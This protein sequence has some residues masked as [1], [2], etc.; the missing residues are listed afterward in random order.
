MTGAILTVEDQKRLMREATEKRAERVPRLRAIFD[1]AIRYNEMLLDN[2]GWTDDECIAFARENHAKA[3]EQWRA[4]PQAWNDGI[5][6]CRNDVSKAGF[7]LE[8]LASGR[9]LLAGMESPAPGGADG[10]A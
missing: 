10:R 4:N 6:Y 5:P 8:D 3:L 7:S 2:P 9:V 1:G